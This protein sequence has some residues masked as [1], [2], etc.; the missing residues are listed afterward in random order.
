MCWRTKKLK[1]DGRH[2]LMMVVSV[3]ELLLPQAAK[4]P[5]AAA[6]DREGSNEKYRAVNDAARE[7]GGIPKIR[8]TFIRFPLRSGHALSR[9]TL[10]VRRSHP[11]GCASLNAGQRTRSGGRAAASARRMSKPSGR[12]SALSP[13]TRRPAIG[14]LLWMP[15][16]PQFARASTVRRLC[17]TAIQALPPS[18]VCCALR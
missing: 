10:A 7:L 3:V 15:A 2:A 16:Q 9:G 13:S 8:E 1:K 18:R 4:L 5:Y 6:S 14:R 17:R 11:G 12:R